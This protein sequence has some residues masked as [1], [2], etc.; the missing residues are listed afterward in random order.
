MMLSVLVVIAAFEMVVEVRPDSV[1]CRKFAPL[2]CYYG[3]YML[4]MTF[5]TPQIL[6][7][8]VWCSLGNWETM[9]IVQKALRVLASLLRDQPV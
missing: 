5:F 4:T 6:M 2:Y 3:T 7:R 8:L 9:A 1:A